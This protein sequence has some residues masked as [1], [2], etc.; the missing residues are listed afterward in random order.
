[1]PPQPTTSA[2]DLYKH[3][4]TVGSQA[5]AGG[6]HLVA[7]C[8]HFFGEISTE[9]RMAGSLA[10]S[11]TGAGQR[12]NVANDV[13]CLCILSGSVRSDPLMMSEEQE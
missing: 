10:N 2:N 1:M 3:V 4:Q 7:G 5:Q 13:V 12:R 6:G 8:L 11:P 9:Q